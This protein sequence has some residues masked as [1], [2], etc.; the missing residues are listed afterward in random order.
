[1]TEKTVIKEEIRF[2]VSLPATDFRDDMHYVKKQITY[3]DG[4]TKPEAVLVKDFKRPVWVTKKT[5][6]NHKEKKEFESIDKLNK[7]LT[8]QSNLNKTVAGLLEK[9]YI[10]NN[11]DEIKNSPYVYGYD[12]S[13]TSLIKYTTLKKNDFVQSAYTVAAFDIETNPERDEIVLITVAFGN[14]VFTAILKN[15]I[16][17]VSEPIERAQKAVKFY[18]PEFDKLECQFMICDNEA[19]LIIESFKIANEW[20]PDLLAIWSMNFDIPKILN[21]LKMLGVSPLDAICDQNVPK[22]YRYCRYKE[23]IAKK[24]KAS[25]QV[26]SVN[27]SLQWHT[28]NATTTF[29]VIDAMCVYRQLR[30]A[31]Q[32]EPNY[33][34]DAILE[35]EKI[36]Q[37]LKFEPADKYSG[38]KW[39]LFLQENYP[40][41]YIVYNIYDC[42]AMLLLDKKTNDLSRSLP[43]FAGITDFS[44]FNSN[45]KKIVDSLFLFGLEKGKVIGTVGKVVEEEIEVIDE[46]S[47]EEDDT[48]ENDVSKHSTLGLKGWIQLLKQSLLIQDGLKCI[49]EYPNLVTN[50]RGLVCD[51][52]STASYPSCT[53]VA[54]VSKATC[55]NELI[56]IND[57]S[58]TIFKE[59]NLTIC[60]G[61]ANMIEYN[62]VMF[63][64][65][66]LDEIDKYLESM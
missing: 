66:N 60:L 11:R 30:M 59:Q 65:L 24:I 12:I 64:L 27:P 20:A 63:G 50:V 57:I 2:A 13:S 48:D 62:H 1:M 18:L 55:V 44:R 61:N 31:K 15:L 17:N 37:K 5:A 14:K 21:K 47:D 56:S 38:I 3:S 6:Q 9:P 19:D 54:N 58:E 33:A 4:T 28:L 53:Q 41:E 22:K 40:I 45:P 35:K 7:V 51:Q 26:Q 36:R 46:D 25:G 52:D 39:H 23:G 34:L 8:N 42:L 16:Q 49:E 10:A 32:E 29:Y 43:S